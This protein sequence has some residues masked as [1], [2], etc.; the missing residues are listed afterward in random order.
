MPIYKA[1]RALSVLAAATILLTGAAEGQ[2]AE[3]L[4]DLIATYTALSTYCDKGTASGELAE[5]FQRCAQRD[6]RFKVESRIE[7]YS[8]NFSFNWS[9]GKVFYAYGGYY[10]T[11]SQR[12]SYYLERPLS[13]EYL[14][15]KDEV[16]PLL[17]LQ[18]IFAVGGTLDE[19]RQT[20][21]LFSRNP[22]LSDR[23]FI[24]LDQIEAF[25]Q[26][27]PS[28]SVV[29]TRRLWVA[30]RDGLIRK[31]EELRSNV[32]E[33]L[34]RTVVAL[35]YVN[36]ARSPSQEEL[37]YTAPLAARYSL[38]NHPAIVTGVLAGVT[39]AIG[40]A[41]W[42]SVGL[43]ISSG[44]VQRVRRRLWKV[45]KVIVAV[46]LGLLILMA[47]VASGGSGHPPP[48]VYVLVAA[49][50]SAIGLL[51]AACLIFSSYFTDSLAQ[52]MRRRRKAFHER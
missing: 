49:G 13:H 9:D 42:L 21:R 1:M 20:Y 34:A 50:Y 41:L 22:E 14:V 18:K 11:G 8:R 17:V 15:P 39:F 25:P 38:G 46:L 45:Y 2:E 33:N 27:D 24:V 51:L 19:I 32:P 30:R 36:T 40:C 44:V 43:R 37:W 52:Y 3:A 16:F 12:T 7:N 29:R 31:Y 26:S 10:D 4:P 23:Q 47:V 35:D 28:I 48:I 5:S 6:G